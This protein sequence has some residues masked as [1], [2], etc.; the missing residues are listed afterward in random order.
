MQMH[1][2][3]GWILASTILSHIVIRVDGVP[4]FNAKA[5]VVMAIAGQQWDISV[6][7]YFA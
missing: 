1:N 2:P 5:H 6:P 7:V 3:K 4:Y